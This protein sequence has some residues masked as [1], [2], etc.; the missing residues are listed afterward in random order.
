M[1]VVDLGYTVNTA[2][3]YV[4]NIYTYNFHGNLN[5]L[6]PRILLST[7][8]LSIIIPAYNEEKRLYT[9]LNEVSEFLHIQSYT[10][11][12]IV[13]EN[14]SDDNTLQIAEEFAAHWNEQYRDSSP[15]IHVLKESKRGKGLAVKRGMLVARGKYRFMCDADFSMP[16][17]EI[18][19]FFPPALNDFDIAIASREAPGAIRYNEP[20]YRHFIG[21]VFNAMIRI[22]ALP[23]LQ[24]TQ[25]GFKC[26][27]API[28]DDLF[29]LQTITGWS[30]DVEL[31]YIG[32]IRGYRIVE[33]PIP[34]YFN[35]DSK[36]SV[37][38]DSYQMG[39]DLLRIRF[40]KRRGE[41]AS[42]NQ[43]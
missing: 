8:F 12:V 16:V 5:P 43:S 32:R 31:L 29:S 1:A 28:A 21:R 22:L 23:D 6:T 18:N 33:I 17:T 36:I 10:A 15:S 42:Q 38:H 9:S 39:L 4:V 26:F 2:A 37:L 13:I 41:Y 40:N 30:F 20:S 3:L 27:R 14:G 19:R 11:E 35:P 24:D 7:P 34:W 25:C